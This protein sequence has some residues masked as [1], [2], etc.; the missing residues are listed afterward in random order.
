MDKEPG[1][2]N[3]EADTRPDYIKNNEV[4][5]GSFEFEG[6]KYDYTLIDRQIQPNLPGFLGFVDGKYLFISDE[7]PEKFREPQ[8]IH[9]V[10]EFTNPE[11]VGKPGRCVE[12]LKREFA[13]IPDDM[14]EEY[15]EYRK[16]FFH[17]LREF[18][19]NNEGVDEGLK[20][21]I[22]TTDEYLQSL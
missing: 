3:I 19:K 21:E 10:D 7:V 6:K 1:A 22:I 16:N 18:Q 15:I 9:E 11:L 13:R 4:G 8:L 20:K 5:R 2:S 12:S 14:K 17:K